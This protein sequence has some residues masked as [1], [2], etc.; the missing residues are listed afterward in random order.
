MV[1]FVEQVERVTREAFA[2][3]DSDDYMQAITV[4]AELKGVGVATASALVAPLRG[5][6]PFMDDV[7]IELSNP[8]RDY[9][10]PIYR[11]MRTYLMDLASS[12][13]DQWD[14]EKVGKALWTAAVL[15]VSSDAGAAEDEEKK[16]EADSDAEDGGSAGKRKRTATGASKKARKASSS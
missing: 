2:A 3:L 14:A 6:L 5:S 1:A 8:V 16:A 7:P 13:G 11:R 4:L 10:A 15:D 9:T 12:L